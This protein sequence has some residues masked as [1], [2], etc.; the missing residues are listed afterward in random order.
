MVAVL[1][2][3]ILA[4]IRMTVDEYL[5]ADLPEGY[6]Y[7]LVEGVVQVTPVPGIL[8]DAVVEIL[9]DIFSM[10]KKQ[11]PDIVAHIT[12]RSA[13][14]LLDRQT[15]REPDFAVYGPADMADKEGKTWKDVTPVLVVEVVST[16]QARRDYEEKRKDYW[17]AGVG[18]YWIADPDRKML[19]VLVRGSSDWSE[20]RFDT[21][22]IYEPT[23]FPGLDIPVGEILP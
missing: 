3:E 1:S 17:D 6:R 8:H 2:P 18:E 7:E 14:T 5:A 12:Q 19:T 4:N 15:T 9:H 16:D 13:V 10:Y 21:S 20:S 23:L 22:M 11:R